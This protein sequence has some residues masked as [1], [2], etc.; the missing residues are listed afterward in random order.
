MSWA[1]V[2]AYMGVC[3]LDGYARSTGFAGSLVIGI[4]GISF[5]IWSG[6]KLKSSRKE[7]D[8]KKDLP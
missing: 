2:S 6:L 8:S 1:L 7:H 3:E 4:V 5:V